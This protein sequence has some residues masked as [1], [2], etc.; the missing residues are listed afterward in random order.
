MQD[1]ISS[2]NVSQKRTKTSDKGIFEMCQQMEFMFGEMISRFEKLE[3]RVESRLS[4]KGREIR[5]N[6]RKVVSSPDESVIENSKKEAKDNVFNHSSGFCTHRNDLYKSQKNK[7]SSRP[8]AK[9]GSKGNFDDM[10]DLDRNLGSIKLKI[11][12]F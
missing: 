1:K 8:W 2:D 9:F 7:E 4:K 5:K 6:S 3:T 12:P 11:P 10:G